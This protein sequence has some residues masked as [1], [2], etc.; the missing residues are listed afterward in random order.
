MSFYPDLHEVD[1]GNSIYVGSNFTTYHLNDI[2]IL[3]GSRL[4]HLNI[5]LGVW[6]GRLQPF[7]PRLFA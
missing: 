2:E 4:H 1:S 6:A 3:S 5:L 7:I